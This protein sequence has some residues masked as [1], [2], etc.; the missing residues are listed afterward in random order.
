MGV[1]YLLALFWSKHPIGSIQLELKMCKSNLNTHF[2]PASFFFA[3]LNMTKK[4]LRNDQILIQGATLR[5]PLHT[6]FLL[7]PK[8]GVLY[9]TTLEA[10]KS[11]SI[12][13]CWLNHPDEIYDRQ[14]LVLRLMVGSILHDFTSWS[15]HAG[16]KQGRL[17]QWNQ[18]C[19]WGRRAY[20]AWGARH[21]WWVHG[22]IECVRFHVWSWFVEL[23]LGW[24]SNQAGPTVGCIS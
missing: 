21:Q 10:F 23:D 1:F 24:S 16:A 14:I 4:S 6:E 17:H 3:G 22:D 15:C 12:A 13:S 5:N 20:T 2:R 8:T 19:H 11:T 9:T 7:F 18:C